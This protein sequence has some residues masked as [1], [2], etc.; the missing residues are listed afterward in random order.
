[1]IGTAKD[2]SIDRQIWLAAIFARISD[3]TASMLADLIP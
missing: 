2:K 1:M 3:L